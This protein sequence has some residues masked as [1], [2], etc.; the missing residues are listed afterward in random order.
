MP[1]P[2]ALALAALA[3]GCGAPPAGTVTGTV[4]VDGRPVPNG[5]ITFSS[6]VGTRDS[7]PAAIRDGKYT[8][9]AIPAGAAKVTVI[10]R[11]GS[12]AEAKEAG[13]GDLVPPPKKGGGK[14]DGSVP[15]R[16]GAVATSGLAHDVTAG[17]QKKD[18]DLA[19]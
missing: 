4:K 10:S 12:P 7:F 9:G 8:T 5:L 19:P 13:G 1:R 6:E 18:F 2:F 3:A 16:Y 11:G 15:A 17:E 14:K